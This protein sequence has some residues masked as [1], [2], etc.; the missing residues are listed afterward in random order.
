M[1]FV[2]C[3][4]FESC[5]EPET[6]EEMATSG[7]TTTLGSENIGDGSNGLVDKYFYDF[8]HDFKQRSRFYNFV[9]LFAKDEWKPPVEA[10]NTADLVHNFPPKMA[11]YSD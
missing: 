11:S 3:W 9:R 2:C 5:A 4:L 8:D 7:P 10:I 6:S 1:A